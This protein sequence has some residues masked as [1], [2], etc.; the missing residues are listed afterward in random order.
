MYACM[1]VSLYICMY[2]CMYVCPTEYCFNKGKI[3]LVCMYVY[4]CMYYSM[5]KTFSVC[6]HVCMYAC[7]YEWHR[8][9]SLLQLLLA[10]GLL[11]G[12]AGQH[13]GG[14]GSLNEHFIKV[15]QTG[16]HLGVA[17]PG[18]PVG[19]VRSAQNKQETL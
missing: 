7:M 5:F 18:P 4:I 14:I 17:V 15:R 3:F 10:L 9:C 11:L 19:S 6:M 8:V 13:L 16:G 2:V 12:L 1:Y